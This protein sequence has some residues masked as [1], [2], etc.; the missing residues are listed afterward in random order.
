MVSQNGD[1]WEKSGSVT[2]VGQ[3]RSG[4]TDRS[5]CARDLEGL[6][7]EVGFLS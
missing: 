4:R 2:C 3:L 7:Q 5:L 1:S 6:Q